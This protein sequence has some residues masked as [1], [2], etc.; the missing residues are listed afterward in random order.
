VKK[1]LLAKTQRKKHAEA[2]KKIHSLRS[3]REKK[4]TLAT[5]TPLRALREKKG[6]SPRRKEINTQR[7]LSEFHPC[8]LCVKSKKSLVKM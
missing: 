6:L 4:T 3:L 7:P 2:A 1:R 5:N 8:A